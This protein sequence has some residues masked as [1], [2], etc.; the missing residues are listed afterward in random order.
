M[1]SLD[2]MPA[3]RPASSTAAR[4]SS[5]LILSA[6]ARGCRPRCCVARLAVTRAS[7]RLGGGQKLE[8]PED[9]TLCR[10]RRNRIQHVAKALSRELGP[11]QLA[12]VRSRK[13]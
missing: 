4:A 12:N 8:W 3:L 13:S 1:A 5:Q 6:R 11:E 9:E 10:H 2:R 7:W